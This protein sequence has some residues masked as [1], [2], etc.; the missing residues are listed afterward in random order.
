M[1]CSA[2]KKTIILWTVY[3]FA[4]FVVY[5]TLSLVFGNFA[6]YAL[7]LLFA[8]I[9]FLFRLLVNPPIL[10]IPAVWLKRTL[11]IAANAVI[12]GLL[13]ALC[14]FII[15]SGT[16]YN[17]RYI[18]SLDYGVFGKGCDYSYD[19]DTGVYTVKAN[20]D[21]LRILQLTDIHLCGS[22]NTIS[23]DRKAIDACY[24]LI[25]EAQPDLII[26]TG[27]LIYSMPVQTFSSNNLIPIYQFCLFMNR[28]G[29]PWTMVYG[30]HD[31]EAVSTYSARQLSGIYRYFSDE[32]YPML[33]AEKQPD[34]Y[35][36]YNQ[37]LRVENA[38]GSLNRILFLIDSNDYVQGS[39]AINDYDSVHEDQIQWY[40][41]TID[42]LSAEEGKKVSSFVFMHIPFHAFAEAQ[43]ALS[44]GS[45]DAVYLFGKNGEG[46]SCPDADSGFF[47]EILKKGSTQ[48]VFVGHDHL[49][50]LGV[51]Y[52][53]VDLVFSKSIDYIAY[54]RIADMN[55]QR[56]ATLITLSLQGGY[57]IAQID[58]LAD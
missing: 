24:A 39:T 51:K 21:G 1:S 15:I 25:K 53:G 6:L 22:I 4:V 36:R 43:A 31:T 47:D 27:D 55:E 23:L 26:V 45:E 8:A 41:Q 13:A 56:G 32:G 58:Y 29:I 57:E 28:V 38:D 37:Y 30:N 2:K 35:G 54:P 18:Q 52:K 3:W 20:G 33:Y 50:N 44:T 49:N 11:L 12:L 42:S 17:N 16:D 46:V 5:I 34:I 48:A 10:R 7:I 14:Y 9:N 19:A 40:S